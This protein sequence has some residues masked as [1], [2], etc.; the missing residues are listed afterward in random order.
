M[1]SEPRRRWITSSYLTWAIASLSTGV[2]FF[3]GTG[4]EPKWFITWLASLPVL[5]LA[6]RIS[7][8]A[9]AAVAFTGYLLGTLN[10]AGY[11]QIGRAH[12]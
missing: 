7:G 6:P 8:K 1:A 9:T 12:V 5:V 4:L 3:F 11:Y 2:L 10:V